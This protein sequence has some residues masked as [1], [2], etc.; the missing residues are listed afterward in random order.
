MNSIFP[1]FRDT[2]KDEA[3][4]TRHK[5]FHREIFTK[6]SNKEK[7]FYREILNKLSL[8][9]I[10]S[11]L[12]AEL[13]SNL[14]CQRKKIYWY[15]QLKIEE[16]SPEKTRNKLIV[17]RTLNAIVSLSSEHS[18]DCRVKA[19]GLMSCSL[20]TLKECRFSIITKLKFLFG[21]PKLVQKWLTEF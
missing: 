6:L 7:I 15:Y 3:T 1:H 11:K 13:K 10:Q 12:V 17:L 16:G 9:L 4:V 5:R 19:L 21:I 8:T 14:N 18:F 2:N 20:K